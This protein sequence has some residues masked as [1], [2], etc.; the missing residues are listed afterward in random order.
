MPHFDSLSSDLRQNRAGRRTAEAEALAADEGAKRLER[1]AARLARGLDPQDGDAAAAL[2][3]VKA[4]AKAARAE[5]DEL[6]ETLTGLT[7]AEAAILKQLAPFTD[8][9]YAIAR[10]DDTIPILMMPVRLETRFKTGDAGAPQ[11]WLRIYP[12][13]CWVDSFTPT[14]TE[15]EVVNA[16]V[17][18]SAIWAANGA[19]ALERGA[20]AGL[21]NAHGAPRA[22]WIVKQFAPLNAKPA[23][24]PGPAVILAIPTTKPLAGTEKDAIA[25]Y[26]KAVWRA[27]GAKDALDAAH[28]ALVVATDLARAAELIAAYPP[29]NPAAPLPADAARDTV[30]LEAAYVELPVVDTRQAAWSQAPRAAL[31]PDRFLFIGYQTANDDAPLIA[32]GNPV[33]SPLMVAPNPSAPKEEQIQQGPDGNLI[34]PKELKWLYDF[35]RAVEVGMAMRIDLNRAQSHGF[36]RVLVIGL[37]ATSNAEQGQADLETLLSNQAHS[38]LGIALAPQGTPTNN[39]ET[40]S[41]G[42]GR[43]SDPDASFD[44]LKAP[45]FTPVSANADKADGQWLAELLGVNPALFQNVEG[46]GGGDRRAARAMNTALWPATLGY[47]FESMMAPAFD[48]AEIGKTRDFFTRHV[49][50]GGACP[51]L[52]IGWQPYGVL[53]ATARSRMGWIGAKVPRISNTDERAHL[54]RL[55]P[56]LRAFDG[57]FATLSEKVSFVGKPGDP[58]QLLLDIVGLHPGS[59]EWT[60]R[61]AESLKTYFNRMK[62]KGLSG[63]VDAFLANFRRQA[64]LKKLRDLNFPQRET[65]PILDLIFSGKDLALKGGVVDDAPL[66]ESDAI[67]VWTDDGDNYLAWLAKA[68]GTSLDALYKQDGFIDDKPPTALLYLMLRHALQLGYHDTGVR[69]YLDAGLYSVA[70]ARRARQDDPFLH[71]KQASVVSESRYQ[72]LYASAAAIT[73]VPDKPVHLHIGQNLAT[74]VAAAS[75]NAQKAAIERLKDEPTARLERVFADH[76]DLCSYRLDAWMLGLVDYQLTEIM[77]NTGEGQ[78]GP[79][80]R[81][82]HLG[83]YAWLEELR[84]E[85]KVLTPFEIADPDLAAKFADPIPLTRDSRNQGHIHAPSLNHAVTAAVLRN[86]YISNASPA[87]PNAFAVNLTSERVRIALGMIEGVRAGQSMSDLLGYQLERG[88]HDRHGE[89]EVDKLILDLRKAFP[90][91]AGRIASTKPPEGVSI[92]AIEARNVVNGLALIERVKATGNKNYPFGKPDLPTASPAERAVI[93]EEV[94]RLLDTHDAVADLALSE[95]VYQAVIGNYD[96][97]ASTYDAYARGNFPPE[98]EVVRTPLQG[99]GLTHRIALHLDPAIASDPNPGAPTPRSQAEPAINA[100]LAAMLPAAGDAACAVSYLEAA[101]LAEKTATVTLADIGL[102]PIDWLWLVK[103]DPRQA[104]TELDDRVALHV[105]NSLGPRPDAPVAIRYME[106]GGKPV[107]LFELTPQIRA[108]GALISRSRPLRATDLA[109][110]A[111]AHSNQDLEPV[112]DKARL[113]KV[114][115]ALA[116]VRADLAAHAAALAI[117]LADPVANRAAIVA[118]VDAE[119]A[120]AAAL[121]E[122]AARFAAPAASWGSAYETRQSLYRKLLKRCADLVTRWDARLARFQTKI[123]EADAAIAD[124]DATDARRFELLTAAE[125]EISNAPLLPQPATPAAF[126]T[127]LVTVQQPLFEAKRDAFDAA[128]ATNAPGLAPLIAEIELLLPV[129]AFDVEGFGLEA[130][131]DAVIRLTQD[132]AALVDR[133]IADFDKRLLDSQ[134][135][136]DAHD[137]GATPAAR[138]SALEA[139]AKALLGED[140]K[141][142]PHFT[143]APALATE[144]ANA[145]AASLSGDLFAHLAALPEPIDLPVDFWLQGVARVRDQ[146]RAWEQAGLYASALGKAE[147]GLVAM[148]FPFVANDHWMALD[149]APDAALNA[150]K[151]LYTAHFA[152]GA[153]PGSVHCGLLI[154]EW[155]EIIPGVDADTGVAFHHDRPNNEAPQAMLLVTPADFTGKWRWDD[156]V[157]A[158]NET[159]DFAKRRAVEPAHIEATPFAPLLP[160]TVMATQVAQLTIA[161][162]L[163]LNNKIALQGTP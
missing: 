67:R 111:E 116:Q 41:S 65:P 112:F 143:L 25:A 80:R 71:I 94:A 39:S 78:D 150:E 86:G 34:V 136:F 66:S 35:D 40:G 5:A 54:A 127:H 159:L 160:A 23:P 107:S 128:K 19:E 104:M 141:I 76:I 152:A 102:E 122:R 84:P 154:D 153:G 123:A 50:A 21:V 22:A 137:A 96:R 14:L 58:H 10:L 92:E 53:P 135:Q 115:D 29:A 42:Q 142:V 28:Q 146:A 149:L 131:R 90:L 95:G 97:V 121:L 158:L 32:L 70:D 129:D 27:D 117:P 132:M 157:D 52:R 9:R 68:V 77:R 55:Y 114:R 38:G 120:S 24:L 13:D 61:Y 11:L 3:D 74:L 57:E 51:S 72:P 89:A 109:L 144:L 37:R 83:G 130:E 30:T 15:T 82:V 1:E 148:Q 17:Y 134:S 93:D 79:A 103:G 88:M 108:L 105:A 124:P 161:A 140:F 20:W 46:A 155:A 133:V 98:P 73:G 126:R 125:V 16:T 118:A 69:L 162:N 63:W 87:N 44:A 59:V 18:W 81:G 31:L 101:T 163:A 12:D 2:K 33:P 99:A 119:I 113:A 60:K 48:E 62:L 156:L 139:A 4:K 138:L 106:R 8:P 147:P 85:G 6:R 56:Y 7:A 75:V 49:V 43:F 91:R 26:W 151:L 45:A 145:H 36:H 100:W 110:T 47:W 64:A